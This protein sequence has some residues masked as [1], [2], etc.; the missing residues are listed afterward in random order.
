MDFS[1]P[2]PELLPSFLKEFDNSIPFYTNPLY[3]ILH[4]ACYSQG[5]ATRWAAQR[6]REQAYSKIFDAEV[7]IPHRRFL[8]SGEHSQSSDRADVEYNQICSR[9]PCLDIDG[10]IVLA[11]DAVYYCCDKESKSQESHCTH[12][13][14]FA[15]WF[16]NLLKLQNRF[17]HVPYMELRIDTVKPVSIRETAIS[18]K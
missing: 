4:E 18:R 11:C 15:L 6:V 10:H 8:A 2:H 14:L 1:G 16:L 5:P 17:G 3:A 9:F 12:L 13:S 7:R